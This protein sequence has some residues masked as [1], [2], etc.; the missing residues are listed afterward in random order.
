MSQENEKDIQS[1]EKKERKSVREKWN[2][3]F[4]NPTVNDIEKNKRGMIK[5]RLQ[6]IVEKSSKYYHSCIILYQMR[7]LRKKYRKTT[8]PKKIISELHISG[9]NPELWN[10]SL[11]EEHVGLTLGQFLNKISLDM[12]RNNTNSDIDTDRPEDVL[13]KSERMKMKKSNGQKN[14]NAKKRK[15]PQVNEKE[16]NK[17]KKMEEAEAEKEKEKEL[18]S[19]TEMQELMSAKRITF[20]EPKEPEKDN[21]KKE[22]NSNDHQGAQT[23]LSF[24]DIFKNNV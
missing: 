1:S 15:V 21:E 16:S 8:K 5:P 3:M 4:K 14:I 23:M 10:I 11:K 24:F 18:D 17:K 19:D 13:S 12:I 22:E 2:R 7:L 9:I 20:D 6:E